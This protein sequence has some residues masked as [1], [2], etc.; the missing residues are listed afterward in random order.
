MSVV[1]YIHCAM[2]IGNG[3]GVTCDMAAVACGLGG[4]PSVMNDDMGVRDNLAA[5]RIVVVSGM[6]HTDVGGHGGL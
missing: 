3:L 2:T 6:H 4:V 1:G 5:I